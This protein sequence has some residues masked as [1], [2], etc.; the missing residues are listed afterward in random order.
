[1]RCEDVRTISAGVWR[2]PIA[3]HVIARGLRLYGCWLAPSPWQCLEQIMQ[4]AQGAD[5]G[6]PSY[7]A[8]HADVESLISNAYLFNEEDSLEWILTC[9]LIFGA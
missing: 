7:Q 3:A 5:G 9:T 8:F 2:V 1:M 6:Y 4:K